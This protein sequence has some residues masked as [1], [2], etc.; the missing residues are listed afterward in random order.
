MDNDL[1]ESKNNLLRYFDKEMTEPERIAFEAEL[2]ADPALGTELHDLEEARTAIMLYGIRQQVSAIHKE[3]TTPVKQ[4][5][6]IKITSYK[7]IIRYSIAAA[8]CLVLIIV[9]IN[10]YTLKPSADGLYNEQYIT[11]EPNGTR[12]ENV[13][14]TP[15]QKAYTQ[16]NYSEVINLYK[17]G[18]AATPIQ[19]MMAGNAYLQTGNAPAAIETFKLLLSQ[20]K[21]SNTTAYNDDGM[22]YLA[23]AYLK[24]K[25]YNEAINLMEKINADKQNIYSN[26]FTDAYISSVKK[27]Q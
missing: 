8:A 4:A 9:G 23:M 20:N 18:S 10:R 27:L 21:A 24:N 12:G 6:V 11:F 22:N 2:K 26:K 1:H 19:M 25:N 5:P 7:K 3:K 13:E 16:K 14:I 15:I 17:A